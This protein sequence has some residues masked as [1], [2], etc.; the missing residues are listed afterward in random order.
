MR[1]AFVCRPDGN[2]YMNRKIFAG[3]FA[4]QG[5]T[6]Y[7]QLN[8]C[9]PK[10]SVHGPAFTQTYFGM[11]S[12]DVVY[13]MRVPKWPLAAEE[14]RKRKRD[15]DWPSAELVKDIVSS[16]FDVVPISSKITLTEN[17]EIEWRISFR[18]A[19]TKL[20]KSFSHVQKECLIA[21]KIFVKQFVQTKYKDEDFLSS[22]IMKTL[23]FWT[24][25]TTDGSLW[26][27]EN[28]VGCLEKLFQTLEKWIDDGFC[29]SYFIPKYNLFRTK[30]ERMFIL[31][32][33]EWIFPLIRAKVWTLIF[34][35]KAFANMFS[36]PLSV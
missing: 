14:W 13:S 10:W 20:V 11:F 9:L 34:E 23:M 17:C 30:L 3:Y 6:V 19:E 21:L 32:F 2:V 36:D 35:C 33:R 26:H 29:P 16:G 15:N 1:A 5:L 24:I 12:I 8:K 31:G 7:K 27:E 18:L 28:I 25:E 4:N 22:Y